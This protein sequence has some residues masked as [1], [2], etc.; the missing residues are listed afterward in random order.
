MPPLRTWFA[1][2][3]VDTFLRRYPMSG[4]WKWKAVVTQ[5]NGQPAIGYYT[6]DEDAGT[7]LP[8]ALNVLSLRGDRISDVCAFIVRSTEDPDAD[9]VRFPDQPADERRLAG[10]FGAFGLPEQLD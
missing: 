1:G 7:H 10:A 3:E 9:Y 8:F 2:A 5:A 4:A 6:W